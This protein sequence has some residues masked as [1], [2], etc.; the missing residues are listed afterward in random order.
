MAIAMPPKKSSALTI[1]FGILMAVF[2]LGSAGAGALYATDHS[3]SQKTISDQNSKITDLQKQL[4]DAKSQLSST[5]KDLTAAQ[6]DLTS[7]QAA[8]KACEDKVQA[9]FNL[10]T[11]A[12][13]P[14]QA[15]LNSALDNMAASCDVTF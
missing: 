14:G 6:D 9:L 10:L 3:S 13:D 12:T 5:K 7:A 2:F 4:D 8:Q 11:Q 15:A 1:V